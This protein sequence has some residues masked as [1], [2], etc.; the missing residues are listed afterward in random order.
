L[1]LSKTDS[2]VEK[3]RN[4]REPFFPASFGE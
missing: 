1:I 3:K 2:E 4:Q